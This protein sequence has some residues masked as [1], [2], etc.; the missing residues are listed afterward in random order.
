[1][2]L[3]AGM[4]TILLVFSLATVALSQP[5]IKER[6]DRSEYETELQRLKRDKLNSVVISGK[7]A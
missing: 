3:R 6:K 2:C 4:L 1:M 7:P 5:T